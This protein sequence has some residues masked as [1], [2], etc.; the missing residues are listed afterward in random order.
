LYTGG[1]TYFNASLTTNTPT[2]SLLVPQPNDPIQIVQYLNP[3]AMWVYSSNSSQVV[4]IYDMGQNM[5]GW[6][7]LLATN[8]GSGANII[9]KHA[10]TLQL[11]TSNFPLVNGD[12]EVFSLRNAKQKDTFHRHH[13]GAWG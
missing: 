13:T 4:T 12:I 7:R 10:E 6:C 9:L 1:S 2:T 11:N 3:V 5:V 8:G